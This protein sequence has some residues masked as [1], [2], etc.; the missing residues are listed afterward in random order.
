MC[1]SFESL[2]VFYF[3]QVPPNFVKQKDTVLIIFIDVFQVK[4]NI[5]TECI[6]MKY[7]LQQIV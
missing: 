3:Y 1:P 6:T 5:I 4:N 7:K 2:K